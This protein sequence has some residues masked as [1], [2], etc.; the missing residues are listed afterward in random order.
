MIKVL[1]PLY[2]TP[3]TE[4]DWKRYADGY[5]K[6]WNIPNCVGSVDGKHIRLRCSPYSGSLFYNYKKYYSIILM[7]VT[8]HLCRFTL[9]LEPMEVNMKIKILFT[10]LLNT[11]KIKESMYLI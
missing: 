11:I 3:P 5:W 2:L 6:R 4:E 8:D 7:A 10:F 9:I 1:E